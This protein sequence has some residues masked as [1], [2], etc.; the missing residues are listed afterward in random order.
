MFGGLPS[1]APVRAP[2]I[3]TVYIDDDEKEQKGGIIK[4]FTLNEFLD[5]YL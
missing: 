3:K 2:F 1:G 5:Q 4:R